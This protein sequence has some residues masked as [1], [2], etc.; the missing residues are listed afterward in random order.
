MW[1]SLSMPVSLNSAEVSLHIK[2]CLTEQ[3]RDPNPGGWPSSLHGTE[4]TQNQVDLCYTQPKFQPKHNKDASLCS[5]LLV[6]SSWE[7]GQNC[8]VRVTPRLPFII[9]TGKDFVIVTFL[10]R[11]LPSIFTKIYIQI[12][13]TSYHFCL[14]DLVTH[15]VMRYCWDLLLS[16][17]SYM[18]PVY[19]CWKW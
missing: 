15:S 10:L 6:I 14:M 11:L 8:A 5:I 18:T 12:C 4:G 2:L 16:C 3:R 1:M 7:W 19:F 17:I 13:T 9:L